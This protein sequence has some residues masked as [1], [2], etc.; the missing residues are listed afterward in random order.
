MNQAGVRKVSSMKP[1]IKWGLKS[2]KGQILR[3]PT[4]FR[5]SHICSASKYIDHE[6]LH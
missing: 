3:S 2:F 1:E 6:T 4:V 5:N